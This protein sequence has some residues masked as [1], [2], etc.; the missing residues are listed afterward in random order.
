LFTV[1]VIF[2]LTRIII[3]VVNRVFQ[4]IESGDLTVPWLHADTARATRYLVVVL[5][6]IFAIVVAYPYVPGSNTDAF[7]GVSVLLGVM[8]SLGSAGLVNQIMSGLTI[9]SLFAALHG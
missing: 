5:V 3:S 7:K 4:Q 2:L 6:W 1:I 8:L 9:R